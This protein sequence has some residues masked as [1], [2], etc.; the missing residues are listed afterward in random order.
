MGD[1]GRSLKASRERALRMKAC[2]YMPH[3]MEH[4]LAGMDKSQA[5]FEKAIE[6]LRDSTKMYHEQK[7]AQ[8]KSSRALAEAVSKGRDAVEKLDDNIG[9]SL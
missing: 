9:L 5:Q 1:I 7:I 3:G 4:A 6:T 2:G 8:R